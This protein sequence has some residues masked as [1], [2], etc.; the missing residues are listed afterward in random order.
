VVVGTT[1]LRSLEGLNHLAVTQGSTREA[2]ADRW[3]RTDIFIRP[4]SKSD[5]YTPWCCSALMTNFHQPESTLLMLISAIF[6][7]E[8][9]RHIYQTALD[10]D[11]RFLSYGDSSLLWIEK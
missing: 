5:R 6:G 4:K 9:T 11:Y 10:S 7:Y 1:A 2:L 8:H 3:L